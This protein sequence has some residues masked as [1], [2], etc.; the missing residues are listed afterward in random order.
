MTIGITHKNK[1]ELVRMMTAGSVDDGKST[2]IGRLL[3]D[4]GNVFDDQ[5]ESVKRASKDGTIDFALF[6][7]G[8]S[9]ERE[10]GITIDVAYRYFDTPTRR[11]VVA[12]VPGHEQYTKN[13]ATAASVSQV[14]LI[15]VDARKGLISQTKRHLFIASLFGISHIAIVINKMDMV[16]FSQDIFEN[17]R[18]D[19]TG[20]IKKLRIHDVQFIPVSATTGDMVVSRGAT[21]SWY[22]GRTLF[23]Y[24]ESVSLQDT[25][26]LI[27]LRFPVQCVVRPHQDFRGYAGMIESGSLAVGDPIMVLPSQRES[28]IKEITIGDT[29]YE[30]AHAGQSIM[31]SLT[32]EID[33]S[34]G[35]M[36][37]RVANK[38]Y[39]NNI[40]EASIVW[41][42]SQNCLSGSRYRLKHTTK[43]TWCTIEKIHHTIDI[44]TLHR[45]KNSSLQ[46]NDVGRVQI[47]TQDMLCADAYETCRATGSF[48]LID[49]VT[50]MTI[51][52]GIILRGSNDEVTK[53]QIKK[54]VTIWLT[55]LSGSGKSTI[56]SALQER[57]SRFGIQAEQLDG[58]IMR[59]HFSNDLG[60]S[61]QD[62][63]ENIKR[64]GYI[65][66]LFSK[67]NV[68]V[69]AS[70]ITPYEQQR[71]LLRDTI[72][73]YVEVHV[74]TPL[75]V[76]E[77]RDV[78]GFYKKARAGEIKNF[79]GIND[80][81][82]PPTSADIE[83]NTEQVTLKESVDKIVHYLEKHQYIG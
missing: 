3:Y 64:A 73:R 81:Y 83:I 82:E 69:I 66:G 2:L 77:E 29:Y 30:T 20:Y 46:L 18:T 27:D 13:M 79:T 11:F 16:H 53:K 26:N 74:S 61:L 49:D 45:S 47:V 21:M 62:R 33:V 8:L 12:D 67:H 24:I 63:N 57:L 32:N 6:T 22:N 40:F 23:D 51:G 36:I 56:A 68:V 4:T 17:I 39:V 38:P 15:L 14:A 1:K 75:H 5:I 80:P 10:Q 28:S 54:G 7:D 71:Q 52:A 37:V 44:E 65:A 55:G 76:C 70:F 41:M 35:D 25:A 58:D 72:S 42:S 50:G 43:D 78:K 60:F 34:R 31:V 59:E 19:V 9:A 48:V